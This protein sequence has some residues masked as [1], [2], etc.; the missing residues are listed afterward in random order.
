MYRRISAALVVVA[1]LV[2]AF[3]AVAFAA[4]SHDSTG[5]LQSFSYTAKTKTGHL[6]VKHGKTKLKFV[7]PKTANC[8]V[9]FGQSG[10]QIP[11]KTLGKSKYDGKPVHVTWTKNSNGSKVAT[12]VSVD[13]SQ[14]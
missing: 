3:S 5:K 8:G 2:A 9:S 12:L 4:T 11:C 13:M 6:R 1:M 14:G 7:V 10:D